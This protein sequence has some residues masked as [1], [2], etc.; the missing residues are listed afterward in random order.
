MK[1]ITL[2]IATI[3]ALAGMASC[4][5]DR[6]PVYQQPTNFVLNVPV[7]ADQLIELQAGNTLELTCSQ[8]D[9]GFAAAAAYSAQMS[10]SEDFAESYDLT[11]VNESS[12]RMQIPQGDI[13]T[14]YC[15][16]KGLKSEEDYQTQYPN[17]FSTT[18]IYFRAV[19]QIPGV[20]NS[21]IES[22]VVAYN[23]IL[24]FFNVAV[25]GYIYLVGAPEGWVGPDESHAEHY[26][27][28]RLF[29]AA[30]AI[31]S[32]IYSGVF[33]I[34][35]G[36]SAMFRFYTALTGWDADSYGVQVDDNA[37]QYPDAFADGTFTHELIKGKGSFWFPNWPGGK[38]TI[39]VDMSD[40]N[41]M[42]VNM[43]AG[44]VEV[45][46][47]MYIYSIGNQFG[48]WTEPSADNEEALLPY[49]LTSRDGGHIYQASLPVKSGDIYFRFATE[50]GG[51]DGPQIGIQEQDESIECQFTNGTF[52]GPYVVGKGS[53]YFNLPA[54][55][56]LSMTVNMD[57][58]TVTYAFE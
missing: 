3:C 15:E 54:D 57:S 6:D 36:D 18:K 53:W 50:L 21:R 19:C 28:W 26:A 11:P 49:R 29:E 25:P 45:V 14:G 20:D 27:D 33:D 31:G 35:A 24:P 51:W 55:G 4:S 8:P 43:T 48:N 32:K 34:P 16:L 47:P 10:L 23:Q 41:N 22:N 39:V 30:D 42:T 7:M 2:Y 52:T 44:E 13:A 58:Q 5:Q 56:T 46:T 17:G 40:P 9:Y 1:K 37:I 12:A 38:M